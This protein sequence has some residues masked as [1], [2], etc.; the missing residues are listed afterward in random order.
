MG[1]LQ[2]I[3]DMISKADD[4][5]RGGDPEEIRLKREE[6]ELG[7]AVKKTQHAPEG[8]KEAKQYLS[9]QRRRAETGQHKNPVSKAQPGEEAGAFRG[10]DPEEIRIKREEKMQEMQDAG[11]MDDTGDTG[12]EVTQDEVEEAQQEDEM[13][14]EDQGKSMVAKAASI[15]SQD[16]LHAAGGS[17]VSP[18]DTFGDYNPHDAN[19]TPLAVKYAY[20]SDEGPEPYF[21]PGPI[22]AG[23]NQH[24]DWSDV[25]GIRIPLT[26]EPV[27]YL[28]RFL[29]QGQVGK[30]AKEAD[31]LVRSL[32]G[33]TGIL[34]CW[35][36][37][38]YGGEFYKGM[39]SD[40]QPGHKYVKRWWDG[41]RWNYEYS[42]GVHPERHGIA[43]SNNPAGYTMP[44]HEEFK[45]GSAEN[46]Y[47]H[48]AHMQVAEGGSHPVQVWD[49][50]TNKPVKKILHMPGSKR[51]KEGNFIRGEDGMPELG[52]RSIFLRDPGSDQGGKRI[53]SISALRK[54]LS[55]VTTEHDAHGDP[56]MHWRS[57]GSGEG[58]PYVMFD[59]RSKLNAN[60]PKVGEWHQRTRNVD[61]LREWVANQQ[62]MQRMMKDEEERAGDHVPPEERKSANEWEPTHHQVWEPHP[63][64]PGIMQ[65]KRGEDGNPVTSE[66][67]TSNALERGDLGRWKWGD[68]VTRHSVQHEDGSTKHI[69]KQQPVL[70]FDSIHDRNDVQSKVLQ[71]NYGPLMRQAE[72]HLRAAGV[73][74]MENGQLSPDSHREAASLIHSVM[75]KA[76]ERAANTYNPNHPSKARF[77]T[78]LIGHVRREMRDQM[79]HLIE[80]E[81]RRQGWTERREAARSGIPVPKEGEGAAEITAKPKS[82]KTAL[83]TAYREGEP[84]LEGRESGGMA[85]RFESPSAGVEG[86][87]E[88]E[89]PEAPESPKVDQSAQQQFLKQFQQQ[90]PE[91]QKQLLDQLRSSAIGRE[92]MFSAHPHMRYV[93]ETLTGEKTRAL[94]SLAEAWHDAADAVEAVTIL[95]KAAEDEADLGASPDMKYLWRDGEPGAHKHMW[96]DPQGNVVRGTNAPQ[97]HP[98]H[99][100]EAGPPQVH[101]Q[102]PTPDVAPHMFDNRGRKLHRPAPEGVETEGNPGYDPDMMHWARKYTD[103][104]TGNEEHIAFHRDRAKNH[105]YALNED[106]RQVDSQLEKIRSWYGSLFEKP[107]LR[108]KATGLVLAL[109]DQGRAMLDGLMGMRVKDV[110]IHGNTY[111]LSYT[112]PESGPHTVMVV[113]DS[114]ASAVLHALAQGKK[115]V[116]PLFDVEGQPLTR[117]EV[118][119]ALDEKFGVTP[120]Q[121][122]VY[123]GT[124]LFS[125]EFQRLVSRTPNLKPEMLPRIADQAYGRVMRMLGH[126]KVDAKTAQKMYVDPIVVEALFMAAVHHHDDEINKSLEKSYRLQGKVIFQGLPVSIENRKGSVRRWYDPHEKREGTTKMHHAYGYI[127]GTKGTDG[128]HVDVYLGP[129]KNSDKVFVIHQKKAPAFKEFDE[130]KCMLGFGSGA[131]AKAAYIKQYDKPGFFGGMTPLSLGDFK[132]KVAA[133]KTRP[134]MIKASGS[135]YCS[136]CNK[137]WGE[138][139]HSKEIEKSFKGSAD[140][141]PIVWTVS[142]SHPDRTPDE[143]LFGEW[144]HSHP[145]HEHDQHWAAFKQATKVEDLPEPAVDREYAH[146]GNEPMPDDSDLDDDETGH[147]PPAGAEVPPAPDDLEGGDDLAGDQG[148]EPPAPEKAAKSI[149]DDLMRMVG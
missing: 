35:R 93:Y 62:S 61:N 31:L 141:G 127:R 68:E 77:S 73:L 22:R 145:M 30:M 94:K 14:K 8:Q 74:R 98:H 137:A 87:P 5:F 78:Y 37:D 131:E 12:D 116:D 122:R 16:N 59:P 34:W 25:L 79:P 43:H 11:E 57:A 24:K 33:Q 52:Q 80:D 76:F 108:S 15:L 91:S 2:L 55:P 85:Q 66:M 65:V 114:A 144:V 18:V 19:G 88:A 9:R 49:N 10:G 130:D 27:Q 117:E 51:D 81:G 54:K 41:G 123:H 42:E 72:N 118:A 102:E 126:Q 96:E 83:Q 119:Q 92:K 7:K 38:F 50:K 63:T 115:A 45:G 21:Q 112:D 47:H 28:R 39:G 128:D 139:D 101:P 135:Q 132:R 44:V 149:M 86:K 121:F 84:G 106:L 40:P 1:K 110:S 13:K 71:E 64:Q 29:K 103:P 23:K 58:K 82:S 133:T 69:V 75:P 146:G 99:D 124:E 134:Q 111:K 143:R 147:Q 142:V 89:T 20:R 105:R 97:G 3:D 107:D 53:S 60:H 129:D 125:K 136:K 70:Q 36:P 67:K 90:P 48:S 113:L 148:L 4:E 56:W 46:A 26:G 104:E 100:P 138:C 120:K 140:A 32:E 6:K 17:Q 109:V 95:R